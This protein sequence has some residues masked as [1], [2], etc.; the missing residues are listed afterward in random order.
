MP[1]SASDIER[2]FERLEGPLFRKCRSMLDDED[3][4]RDAT[5]DVFVKLSAS[6][7]QLRDEEAELA[8]ALQ[9]AHNH[10]LNVLRGMKRRAAREDS[11]G[12]EDQTHSPVTNRQLG[13]SVLEGMSETSRALVV[14]SLV[15]GEEH[16][17]LAQEHGVSKKTV[18]R[19]LKRALEQA[20]ALLKKKGG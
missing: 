5:Q 8:W 10:C 19:K 2:M 9:A 1:R 20:R 13:R 16:A 7:D 3:L 14:G 4:A 15:D 6:A 12:G 18:G 17:A 11:A